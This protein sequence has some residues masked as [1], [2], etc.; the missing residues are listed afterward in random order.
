M[1]NRALQR[2]LKISTAATRPAISPSDVDLARFA[3]RRTAQDM[4]EAAKATERFVT[5]EEGKR[6]A[7]KKGRFS[8]FNL[9][10]AIET[11]AGAFRRG[12]G[13]SSEVQAHYGEVEGTIGADGDPVDVF[14][15]P[16]P[17]CST[18]LVIFQVDPATGKFDE[19]KVMLGWESAHEALDTYAAAFSDGLGHQRIGG[20]KDMTLREF[21]AWLAADGAR[22]DPFAGG[23]LTKFDE[24]KVKRDE[25]GK[26]TFK[27]AAAVAAGA[28]VAAVGAREGVKAHLNSARRAFRNEVRDF[29]G[30]FPERGG[31]PVFRGAPKL[32]PNPKSRVYDAVFVTTGR[33]H[34]Q[35]YARDAGAVSTY[36][37]SRNANIADV[38]TPA[39]R[40]MSAV[41]VAA[42]M[43]DAGEKPAKAI[44]TAKNLMMSAAARNVA[45]DAHFDPSRA[46]IDA[47]LKRGI[48]GSSRYVKGSN[49]RGRAIAVYQPS[50]H[51]RFLGAAPKARVA[52]VAARILRQ[53]LMVKFDESKVKRDEDGK[54]T[55]KDA[56]AASASGVAATAVAV[57][58]AREGV[59]AKVAMDRRA[60]LRRARDFYGRFNERGGLPV[61]RGAPVM[62]PS[63]VPQKH[64]AVYV[65][66][67]R[68]AARVYADAVG[69]GTSGVLIANKNNPGR[70]SS[71]ILSRATKTAHILD[72]PVAFAAA[73]SKFARDI[74]AGKASVGIAAPA[75]TAI[76]KTME[77]LRGIGRDDFI[78][79]K[80][81]R[82]AQW[83]PDKE[84]IARLSS[85]GISGTYAKDFVGRE[86][87][88][89]NT[90]GL[91]FLGEAL[92][93]PKRPS[94]W[95]RALRAALR[96][97]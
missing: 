95:A 50:K 7:Y 23:A 51:L 79:R 78:D 19:H 1:N 75:G 17:E 89:Y 97:R 49:F 85:V 84:M 91:R 26:F 90:R 29:Y 67:S 35:Q 47:S 62:D 68:R 25:E 40:A 34:A 92:V 86:F 20:S 2:L 76:D 74:A 52:S 66:S 82:A 32:D 83:M 96:V 65:T 36:I 72:D 15:R 3:I 88:L 16:E 37:L 46:M 13:W 4:A 43:I 57:V 8:W 14:M 55:F 9:P 10:I 77:L 93:A 87:A 59:K 53:A 21:E 42:E 73:Q 28:A 56:A 39:H 71:Y 63:P 48:H 11:P 69:G 22:K 70:I 58:G 81:I 61:F 6:G 18:C 27:D 45:E 33:S 94:G 24:S 38:A 54:F 64:N 31:L 80:L 41:N 5:A 60:F 30:R 44:A 12:P